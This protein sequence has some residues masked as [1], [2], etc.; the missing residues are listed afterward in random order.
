MGK[1]TSSFTFFCL[2]IIYQNF[3]TGFTTVDIFQIAHFKYV[4]FIL[5]QLYFKKTIFNRF[6]GLQKFGT[7]LHC[8][9]QLHFYDN[10]NDWK[11]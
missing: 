11:F 2:I 1:E 5:F 7:Y 10:Y 4:Q 3:W 6:K 9:D 8:F